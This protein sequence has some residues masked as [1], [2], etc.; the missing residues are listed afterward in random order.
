MHTTMDKSTIIKDSCYIILHRDRSTN[1]DRSRNL[2]AVIKHIKTEI[3]IPILVVEQDSSIN[4]ELCKKL[5]DD[6]I[7][8]QFIYNPG[9]FNRSWGY[10]CAINFTRYKK[11]ILADNDLVLDNHDLLLGLDH[12]KKYNIVKPFNKVYDLDSDATIN[13]INLNEYYQ[14]DTSRNRIN[15]T[16]GGLLM[17]TRETFLKVGGYDE[18]FEGW[19]GE[20]DEMTLHLWKYIHNNEITLHQLTGN[21]FHLYHDRSLYDSWIQP[22]YKNN[23]SYINDNNRNYNISIGRPDKYLSKID[24]SMIR[25]KAVHKN[26]KSDFFLYSDHTFEGGGYRPNGK[27]HI[28]SNQQLVLDWYHWNQELLK[29]DNKGF[30]NNELRLTFTFLE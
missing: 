6:G 30:Y 14:T 19:G 16:A 29:P 21:L 1:K 13:C 7:Q 27:W 9:L 22:N 20:D 2:F 17:I 3:D 28:D 11:L 12:L 18:R 8:Y 4:M 24:K 15:L 25:F 26:W 10:N 23:Y 5:L